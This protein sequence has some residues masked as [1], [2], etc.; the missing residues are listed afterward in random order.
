MKTSFTKPDFGS[1]NWSSPVLLYMVVTLLVVALYI[2]QQDWLEN[3]EA[4]IQDKIVQMGR[5]EGRPNR[6]VIV[7]IDDAS[8]DKV[9]EWPWDSERLAYL[10]GQL[11]EYQPAA[12]GLDLEL[13]YSDEFDP[14]GHE[15]LG[16]VIKDAGNIVTPLDFHLTEKPLPGAVSPEYLHKGSFI[17]AGQERELLDYPPLLAQSVLAP[18]PLIV[19]GA[20]ALGHVNSPIDRDG[21][22]RNEPLIIKLAGEYYPSM[23]LQLVRLAMG[24]NRPQ[25]KIDPGDAVVLG[26]KRIPTDS[27][28]EMRLEYWGGPQTFP[29]ISAVKILEGRESPDRLKGKIVLV[30]VSAGRYVGTTR[31]PVGENMHRTERIANAVECIARA[32]YVSQFDLA[33]F[34]EVLILCGIGG[35]SALVLPRITLQYRLV[36][37]SM[38]LFVIVNLNYILYSSFQIITGTLYPAIEVLLFLLIS[39]AIKMQRSAAEGLDDKPDLKKAA[40][41]RKPRRIVGANV[42]AVGTPGHRVEIENDRPR[43]V[44]NAVISKEELAETQVIS[45]DAVEAA[46]T[47]MGLEQTPAPQS[48]DKV[49]SVQGR[50]DSAKTNSVMDEPIMS[51]SPT[52][53]PAKHQPSVGSDTA[54]ALPPGTPKQLGRYE[55]I[56]M[57]GK[58][59]MGAVFKGKD[60]AI[61]RLVALKTIRFDKGTNQKEIDEL[62]E[63]LHREARAAGKLSH[64]NIV[65]IYDVGAEGDLQYIAMEFL[66]GQ[67]LENVIQKKK[68]LNFKIV[69]KIVMQVAAAMEYAHKQGIVHRD[70]KPA[71]IM[72]LDDFEA[73]VADFGIARF[74]QPNMTMTQTGI[75]LGTPNYISP[76]QLKG[77]KVDARS[78]IFSLGVVIY[79]LM[80]KQRPFAGKNLSQ[81]IFNIL[82]TEPERP[83]TI[84]PNVPGIFDLVTMRCL[85][86]DPFDRYQSAGEIASDLVDF[87]AAYSAKTY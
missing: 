34:L 22:V 84:D 80:T 15:F 43:R 27:R 75:A 9:G 33:A 40:L 49:I 23:A 63:R 20:A 71:N 86:K 12:I 29:T 76:E 52:A 50:E 78:D 72:V 51:S 18:S 61:D 2:D 17:I 31:T 53:E 11:A 10:V 1:I 37:L 83:S 21:L 74:D 38:F 14:E 82:N 67:T 5:V 62:R 66:E 85:K 81:L 24:A 30:G 60:P 59:A 44:P 58:G 39:P 68:T 87:V 42:D 3:L 79:E 46:R 25:M 32:R 16:R 7:T 77:E 64:P 26:S 47:M 28:G 65:T 8:V 6:T 69:A 41:N 45:E 13:S 4:K 36:V 70:I 35:F 48:E 57:V 19:K 73:K 55:L 56:E 54:G